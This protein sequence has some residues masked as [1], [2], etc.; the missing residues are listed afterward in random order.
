MTAGDTASVAV[1]VGG[2]AKTVGVYGNASDV[3][4][5]FSGFLVA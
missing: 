1:A 2:G 4:T 3:R 5:S